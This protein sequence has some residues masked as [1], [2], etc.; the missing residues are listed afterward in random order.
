MYASLL[1]IF[2]FVLAIACAEGRDE[3]RSS[4]RKDRAA[5]ATIVDRLLYE[6]GR[7]RVVV[8]CSLNES[9]HCTDDADCRSSCLPAGAPGSDS[10]GRGVY[11]D[12][13]SRRCV[14]S[15]L[16]R[17]TPDDSDATTGCREVD[18]TIAM[19]VK[20]PS[21]GVGVQWRCVP[22]TPAASAATGSLFSFVCG[23]TG[24]GSALYNSRVACECP[25]KK[26][27]GATDGV[28]ATVP[29]PLYGG[30]PSCVL[31]TGNYLPR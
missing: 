28:A 1:L 16:F 20:D 22:F 10:T 27:T 8:D 21:G 19:V 26:V 30:I 29:L 4:E 3:S 15:R 23:G 31:A 9:V 6:S 11:C 7:V 5:T 25:A 18:G 17:H 14:T 12:R 24:T 2:A 13:L